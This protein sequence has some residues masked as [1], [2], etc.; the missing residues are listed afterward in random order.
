MPHSF[1]KLKTELLICSGSFSYVFCLTVVPPQTQ[2][3]HPE[4]WESPL[5]SSCSLPPVTPPTSVQPPDLTDP[6][7]SLP[8]VLVVRP[9]PPCHLALPFFIAVG[10]CT[11]PVMPY[12]PA[13][14]DCVHSPRHCAVSL[15]WTLLPSPQSA[16]QTLALQISPL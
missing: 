9:P 13:I 3:F 1:R 14:P 6:A 5:S 11:L 16:W 8:P 4:T 15:P 2:S 12:A 7:S 10:F